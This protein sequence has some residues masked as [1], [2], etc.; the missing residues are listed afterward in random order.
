MAN[1]LCVK[2]ETT[3]EMTKYL[4]LKEKPTTFQNLYYATIIFRKKFTYKQV[5]SINDHDL[6]HE[7][8]KPKH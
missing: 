5:F 3:R 2:E 6:I 1:N 8:I 4:S 7:V